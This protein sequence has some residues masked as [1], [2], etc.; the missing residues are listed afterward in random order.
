[1]DVATLIGLILA[2]G[3]IVGSILV[4]GSITAFID[5]PSL[6]IVVGGTFAV[7]L[8]S[9]PLKE[10][11]GSMKV[12]K[13]AFKTSVP[14]AREQLQFLVQ[15]A[16]I[17]R[18][19]GV[20]ALEKELQSVQDEFLR[21]GMQMLVDGIDAEKLREAL[22]DELYAMDDRHQTGSKIF[23]TLGATAPA[24]GLIGT[25]IGLVQML[26]S[27]DDPSKI[28]PAMAVALLTTFYGALFANVIFTPVSGKLLLR[29]A[30][31]VLVRNIVIKGLVGIA[32]GENPRM[33]GQRLQGELS[34]GERE[35]E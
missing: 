17:S 9:Y 7:G 2:M 23:A 14:N 34:P 6:L 33:L 3:L 5:V 4:G 19:E 22:E 16:E 11:L 8:V 30:Q 18:K 21:K 32:Q 12:A 10:M 35:Q 29:N 26:Q 25:L 27:M 1:M 15:C 20:L 24:M 28:G 13:H 31:E